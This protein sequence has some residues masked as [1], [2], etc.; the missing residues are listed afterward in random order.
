MTVPSVFII[1]DSIS[2]QYGPYLEAYLQGWCRY[3]RKTENTHAQ[4]EEDLDVPSGP[5]GGDSSMVRRYLQHRAQSKPINTELMLVNC[6]LHDI[7]RDPETAAIQVP[8][9][10]Y[11]ENLLGII[12]SAKKMT[13]QLVWIRTTPC[14]DAIH[15]QRNKQFYRY[16]KDCRAYNDA[17]DAI[18]CREGI[19]EIDLFTLTNNL[20][21]TSYIDHVHF[22]EEVRQI[23]AAFIAGWLHSYIRTHDYEMPT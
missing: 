15:N 23:Q 18:M 22:T 7:K 11:Q 8:L 20:G 3:L 4:E 6:G 9:D 10:T 17:A 16:A 13:P 19:P 12:D 21:P 1:G 2:M 5:N 14:D